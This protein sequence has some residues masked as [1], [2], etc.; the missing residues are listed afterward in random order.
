MNKDRYNLT[1]EFGHVVK[2][3]IVKSLRM[4]QLPVNI[5]LHKNCLTYLSLLTSSEKSSHSDRNLTFGNT[6]LF[7]PWLGTASFF[8]GVEKATY[9]LPRS[10]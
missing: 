5:G 6:P 8:F 9:G 7:A 1:V 2:K 10:V 4:Q 3:I